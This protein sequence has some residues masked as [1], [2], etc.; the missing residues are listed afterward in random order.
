MVSN[1][2]VVTSKRLTA[3]VTSRKSI[4]PD[5]SKNSRPSRTEWS[6]KECS[7]L[8]QYIC[9]FWNEAYTD[10]WPMIKDPTFWDAC[11]ESVNKVYNSSRTGLCF[12]FVIKI[13]L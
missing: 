13:P 9:L 2:R 3:N 11:A 5:K 8:I 6:D 7:A 12:V 4:F 1:R 10:K